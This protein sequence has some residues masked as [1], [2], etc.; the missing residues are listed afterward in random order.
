M[1]GLLATNG[2]MLSSSY[3]KT[4]SPPIHTSTTTSPTRVTVTP[5]R[6]RRAASSNS[7]LIPPIGALSLS[8]RPAPHPSRR[9]E[10]PDS[11]PIDP[12]FSRPS[13]TPPETASGKPLPPPPPRSGEGEKDRDCSPSPSRGGGGGRG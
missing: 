8:G 5:T 2:T 9:P 3:L 7:L 1:K 12:N 6:S 13:T 4:L 10:R 11:L